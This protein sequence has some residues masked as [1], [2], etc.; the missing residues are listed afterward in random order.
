[1]SGEHEQHQLVADLLVGQ[2]A[3]RLRIDR[4][5]QSPHQRRFPVR[6]RAHCVQDLGGQ[7]L[8]H[9]VG[10]ARVALPLGRQPSRRVDR[11]RR[12]VGHPCQRSTQRPA[13]LV[14]ALSRSRP[15]TERPSAQRQLAALAVQ[16]HEC[17][18][19]PTIY[20]PLRGRGHVS[21]I[22]RHMLLG[23][24]RLQGASARQPSL[25]R[26]I[27]QVATHQRAQL[28]HGADPTAVGDLVGAAQQITGALRR[29]DD[30][31]VRYQPL[32]CE[33]QPG[34]RTPGVDQLLDAI[35]VRPHRPELVP[36]REPIL[37][38]QP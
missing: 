12:A 38:R 37:R 26:K 20:H 7:P 3:T 22:A 19:A 5:D 25:V 27:E 36:V 6:V 18:F 29:G 35:D 24:H 10:A 9:V 34:H 31:D 8:Q 2:R 28:D 30:D 13:D 32:G 11:P 21:R 17:A 33:R 1:M 16:I 14:G 4:L 15:S 23:E